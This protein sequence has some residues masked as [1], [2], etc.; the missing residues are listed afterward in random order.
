VVEALLAHPALQGLRRVMQAT[1]D[2]HD[3]YRSYGFT[4]LDGPT[5]IMVRTVA[6]EI[7]YG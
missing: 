4:D 5:R 1:S 3:L 6:S 7:L 2:A